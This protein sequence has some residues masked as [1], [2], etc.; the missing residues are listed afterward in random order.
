M[1]KYLLGSH[2]SN[3]APDYFLGAVKEALSY[4]ATTFMIYSGAPQNTFRKSTSEMKVKEGIELLKANGINL[5]MIVG[6]APYI[7]NLGNTQ[8]KETYELA[9]TFLSAELKRMADLGIKNV[10][11][12]PGAHVGAGSEAG[13]AKI[14]EGLN[15]VLDKDQ[16][17][18][19][20]CLETMAGKGS[21]IGITFQELADIIKGVNNKAQIGVCLDTCHIND[22]GYDVSDID[23]VLS[24]FDRIIGFDYLKIL[25]INDSKNE[26]GA[27]KDRHEN[28]GFGTIGFQTLT[29]YITDPRLAHIPKILE[30][31]Y[32]ENR[33]PYLEEIAMIN[34]GNF[35]PSLK[36][37]ISE[38][39]LK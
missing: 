37:K 38:K 29:K 33:P 14:I 36:D 8:K 10:V 1:N 11:L 16:S 5:D 12:H 30:T 17:G 34:A 31:P 19:T 22:A 18:V 27:R 13:I 35:D 21:E 32:V 28:I 7:I 4:G 20:V 26:R 39:P 25:H 23:F 2:V 6:H 15:T 9:V 3:N 24:E